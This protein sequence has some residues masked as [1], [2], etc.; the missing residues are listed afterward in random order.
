M[1]FK[2][3]LL[4]A[5]LAAACSMGGALGSIVWTG[6]GP[7]QLPRMR[8]SKKTHKANARKAAKSRGR[9]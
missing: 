2:S 5:A 4:A 3:T 1:H 8:P 6:G 9:K 7:G